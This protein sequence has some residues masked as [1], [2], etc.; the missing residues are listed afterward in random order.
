VGLSGHKIE[1][2]DIAEIKTSAGLAY[3][4]YTHDGKDMG[5]LVRVLPGLYPSRPADFA[6]LAGQRELYFIFYTLQYAL[7]RGQTEV[8]SNQPIPDWARPIPVMRHRSGA[9]WRMVSALAPLTMEFLQRTPVIRELTSEQRKLSIHVLRPHPAMVA[10]L[11]RRWTPER[12]EELEEQDRTLARVRMGGQQTTASSSEQTMRH[13][14]YFADRTNAEKAA[15]WFQSQGFSV[16]TILGAD[17][18]NWLTTVKH[19]VPTTVEEMDK[20]RDEIEALAAELNGEYDGWEAA[21][22]RR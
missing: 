7:Q 19:L 14:L 16:E 15:Q 6:E 2:G 18:E 4:Q 9:S 13:Y 20:L 5:Q 21:E 8:V 11:A 17:G 10:E 12:S 3:V 1:L 22:G